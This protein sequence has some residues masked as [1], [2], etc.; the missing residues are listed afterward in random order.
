LDRETQQ[1]MSVDQQSAGRSAP[2][3][4]DHVPTPRI[5]PGLGYELHAVII[6]SADLKYSWRRRTS[7]PAPVHTADLQEI[8]AGRDAATAL[9][10]SKEHKGVVNLFRLVLMPTELCEVVSE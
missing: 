1:R 7:Q 3:L 5:T 9:K 4:V 8:R 10:H 6:G 2:L